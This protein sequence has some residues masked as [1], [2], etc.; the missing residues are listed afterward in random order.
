M[1]LEKRAAL[2]FADAARAAEGMTKNFLSGI[3]LEDG[4]TVAAYYPVR[5]EMDVLPLLRALAQ[6]GHPIAL[7]CV[8]Q[9]QGPLL[10]RAWHENAAMTAGRLGLREPDAA[11]CP[12]VVPDVVIVPMLGFDEQRNR[13]GYGKGHYD[14]TLPALS[15]RKIGVAYDMQKLD[16]VPA[17][18]YDVPMDVI[19]TEKR[20]YCP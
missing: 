4:Q 6:R 12:E 7:P 9:M 15:A 20:V 1:L 19:V 14:R 17:D 11:T 8:V 16:E 18:P 5:N 13:L 10:F 2:A 3:A